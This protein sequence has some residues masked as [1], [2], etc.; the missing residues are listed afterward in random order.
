MPSLL[1]YS[2]NDK[3][4]IIMLLLLFYEIV[5][6]SPFGTGAHIGAEIRYY[7]YYIIICFYSPISGPVL[8][9]RFVTIA[10]RLSETRMLNIHCVEHLLDSGIF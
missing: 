4:S 9:L 1:P 6:V 10:G 5:F 8:Q 3:V 7:Y 2:V